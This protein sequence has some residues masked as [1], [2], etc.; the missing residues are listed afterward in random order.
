[1]LAPQLLETKVTLKSGQRP[2]FTLKKEAGKWT[3]KKENRN[4]LLTS[5]LGLAIVRHT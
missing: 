5:S 3:L 4:F 1:V 2:I